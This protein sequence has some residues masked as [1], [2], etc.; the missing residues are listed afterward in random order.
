MSEFREQLTRGHDDGLELAPRHA[1]RPGAIRRVISTHA[2]H[3]GHQ[4]QR[5]SECNDQP[6]TWN[7][8]HVRYLGV[9]G[10]I[11]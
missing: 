7:T 1:R 5:G 2:D 10:S 9:A 3:P 11:L 8:S 6:L 4:H